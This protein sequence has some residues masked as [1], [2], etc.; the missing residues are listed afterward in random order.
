MLLESVSE[1]QSRQALSLPTLL[2]EFGAVAPTASA[3][4]FAS[5]RGFVSLRSV[6][7]S[8][9]PAREAATPPAE[10][11][12]PP[13]VSLGIHGH[14]EGG[15]EAREAVQRAGGHP[16]RV[17]D[18]HEARRETS[19]RNTQ[20]PEGSALEARSTLQTETMGGLQKFSPDTDGVI[21]KLSLATRCGPFSVYRL[22]CTYMRTLVLRFLFILMNNAMWIW[23]GD[24]K[25]VL[26][27]LEAAFPSNLKGECGNT[28]V[29][30]CLF[31]SDVDGSS[32]SLASK[33]TARFKRPVFLS[34]NV[35]KADGKLVMFIQHVLQTQ[36]EL[37]LASDSE[38][39][40]SEA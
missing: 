6:A 27:D 20:S 29:S 5:I 14:S 36:T 22:R 40:E 34:I 18:C 15:A 23:V 13:P 37:L 25:E 19:R 3:A 31:S 4:A 8:M 24:Q 32:C 1:S 12:Q 10:P 35:A 7:L 11:A 33:L 17:T 38:H 26:E 9:S 21:G 16:G 2:V 39:K 30:T 28:A